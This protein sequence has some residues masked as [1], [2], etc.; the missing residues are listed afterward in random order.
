MTHTRS[1]KRK[2]TL[3]RPQKLSLWLFNRFSQVH[4]HKCKG[5]KRICN[6]FK[7]I[8]Q[9]ITSQVLSVEQQSE[10][11]SSSL[12][13]FII[14]KRQRVIMQ[15]AIVSTL[16]GWAEANEFAGICDRAHARTGTNIIRTIYFESHQ[17]TKPVLVF[18][19]C[20]SSLG[21]DSSAIFSLFSLEFYLHGEKLK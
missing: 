9:R 2:S 13:R 8:R 11:C 21:P 15:F 6:A 1:E 16:F 17:L 12:F 7:F 3:K 19:H 10:T 14:V 18:G 5:R 20:A 4:A